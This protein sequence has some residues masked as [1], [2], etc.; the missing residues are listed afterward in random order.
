ME[1]IFFPRNDYPDNAEVCP[2]RLGKSMTFTEQTDRILP[3][4]SFGW[5]YPLAKSFGIKIGFFAIYT[6]FSDANFQSAKAAFYSG[7]VWFDEYSMAPSIQDKIEHYEEVTDEEFIGAYN[8]TLLPSFFNAMGKKPIALSYAYG[9]QSFK[10]AV[11]PFYLG[12]RNSGYEYHTDYGNGFGTPNNVAYSF[13]NFKSRQSTIRWYDKAIPDSSF[14]DGINEVASMIDTTK[15]NGGWLN[16]FTHFHSVLADGHEA[17]YEQ[18]FQMLADKNAD[19]QIYFAG[20][21]EALAY[22]VYRQ[23]ITKVAMYSPVQNPTSQMVI[24][25]QVDNTIGIDT[26]LLQVPISVKFSTVGTPLAGKTITSDRNLVSLGGGEYIVE[27]PYT[28]RFP[29]ATVYGS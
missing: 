11:C 14:T 1:V 7:D 3:S 21:G 17:I 10:D 20:Y 18:Y 5:V 16:N 12:A 19:G 24:R 2:H 29:Y 26:D 6:D 27:I 9:V 13:A 8:E 4:G 22:L 28:G 15:Q 25:L 23:L